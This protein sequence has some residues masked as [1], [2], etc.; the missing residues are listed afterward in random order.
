MEARV[1][2]RSDTALRVGDVIALFLEHD[3]RTFC[4]GSEGFIDLDCSLRPVDTGGSVPWTFVDSLWE[5]CIKFQYDA[6]EV[7]NQQQH[8]EQIRQS[9]LRADAAASAGKGSPRRSGRSSVVH[10]RLDIMQ[11]VAAEALKS[12]RK[13]NLSRNAEKHGTPLAYGENIQ[14]R[15][16]KSGK[17]LMLL[18]K[19]RAKAA[20]CYEVS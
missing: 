12:E 20:G 13:S 9:A 8:E 3:G 7:F 17:F 11:E 19:H 2:G 10:E 1:L 4:I 5:V 15:H 14:L 16:A 18:P 6:Q